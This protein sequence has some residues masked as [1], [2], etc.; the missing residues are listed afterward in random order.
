MIGDSIINVE[1]KRSYGREPILDDII[2][3][4]IYTVEIQYSTEGENE[5]LVNCINIRD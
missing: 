4:S 1:T 3:K 2:N 5:G